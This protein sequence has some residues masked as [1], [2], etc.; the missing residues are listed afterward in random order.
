MSWNWSEVYELELIRSKV[1]SQQYLGIQTNHYS[2]E[3]ISEE[4]GW[5][6]KNTDYKEVDSFKNIAL[7]LWDIILWYL[8][9][10]LNCL[11][12]ER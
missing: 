3:N 2:D 8:D 10:F 9:L 6:R 5:G 11:L 4:K 7:T 12:I 1:N